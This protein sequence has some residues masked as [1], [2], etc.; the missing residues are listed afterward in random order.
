MMYHDNLS[1]IAILQ[2]I[3]Y[4]RSV[5]VTLEYVDLLNHIGS[6]V[7]VATPCLSCLHFIV[8]SMVFNTMELLLLFTA[9]IRRFVSV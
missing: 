5:T 2:G 9:K 7:F 4:S 6:Q 3:I 8:I 1:C